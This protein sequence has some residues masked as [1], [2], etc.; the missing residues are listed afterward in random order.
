L[1]TVK[2]SAETA[3]PV[4]RSQPG[5]VFAPSARG[6]SALGPSYIW[7]RRWFLGVMVS[8]NKAITHT[9]I[10]CEARPLQ[11]F[12]RSLSAKSMFLGWIMC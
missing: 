7:S 1:R 4:R 9:I 5:A 12:G 8:P 3:R 10:M 2:C 11:I 6:T